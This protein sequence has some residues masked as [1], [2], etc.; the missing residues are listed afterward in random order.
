M[1][2][3]H[4]KRTIIL[5]V[6][7]FVAL[8]LLAIAWQLKL[9][10]D[11]LPPKLDIPNYQVNQVTLTDRTEGAKIQPDSLVPSCGGPDCLR[12]LD[13]P[14]LE[15]MTSADTWLHDDDTVIG[16]TFD[17]VSR[18]Y[19]LKILAYH[20]VVNDVVNLKPLLITYSPLTASA[21]AFKPLVNGTQT[22]FGISGLVHNSS[23]ILYDRLQGN[24]W[25]QITGQAILGPAAQANESLQSLPLSLTTWKTWKTAHPE[26]VVAS[27]ATGFPFDYEQSPYPNYD[28]SD[29]LRFGTVL[30]NKRL[31][32]KTP[33]YGLVLGT[34][35]KAYP[36]SNITE[37]PLIDHI[38]ATTVS[39]IRQPDGS[40]VATNTRTNELLYPQPMY[41]FI[42][43]LLYPK[44]L[45][46]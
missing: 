17:G 10:A 27:R 7:L 20:M 11:G 23:I 21:M 38:G 14:R 28:S 44:T 31:P 3:T 43:A 18:A 15:P 26:T 12:S 46:Y 4:A 22:Q 5:I 9:Y 33:I 30:S 35:A 24:L 13:Q 36:A 1:E 29:E 32:I 16:L 41:W 40:V 2:T 34:T 19:P 25:E 39:I 37:S 42:W 6:S 8:I 45:V